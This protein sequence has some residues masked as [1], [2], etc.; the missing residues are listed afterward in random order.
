MSQLAYIL[1]N[2]QPGMLQT[3][4]ENLEKVEGVQEIFSVYGIYDLIIKIKFETMEELKANVLNNS[5]INP[6]IKNSMTMI[7]VE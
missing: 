3:I 4:Q 1:L 2:V 5:L 6:G 7:C